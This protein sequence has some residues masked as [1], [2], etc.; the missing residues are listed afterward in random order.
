MLRVFIVSLIKS[1]DEGRTLGELTLKT[2]KAY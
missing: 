2:R 1:V